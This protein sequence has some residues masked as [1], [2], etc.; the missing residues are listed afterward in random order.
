[1][2]RR[3]RPLLVA[4]AAVAPLAIGGA[5]TLGASAPA[6]NATVAT[7]IPADSTPGLPDVDLNASAA[8]SQQQPFRMDVFV[9][10]AGLGVDTDPTVP[11]ATGEISGEQSEFTIDLGSVLGGME[12]APP[13]MAALDLT[14]SVVADGTDLYLRAP[15]LAAMAGQ[16]GPAGDDLG[17]LATL[18]DGWG[19]IDLTAVPGFETGDLTGTTGVGAIDPSALFEILSNADGAASIGTEA[20]RG[21]STSGVSATVNLTDLATAM[22]GDAADI[23]PALETEDLDLPIEAW[24]DKDGLIRRITLSIDPATMQDAAETGGVDNAMLEGFDFSMTLEMY[25]YSAPDIA[26]DVPTEF[27]DITA[28]IGELA[29]SATAGV[30][31]LPPAPGASLPPGESMPPDSL[32][33]VTTG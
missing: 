20:I 5:S 11:L 25:D 3:P 23:D 22:G 17:A 31:G 6:G 33:P 4:L 13:E 9:D 30:P 14:M 18:G 19:Y 8:T 10:F 28:D 1:M 12:G 16:M 15:F 21:V 27:V 29:T 7:T 24:I 26:I 2:I 32:A